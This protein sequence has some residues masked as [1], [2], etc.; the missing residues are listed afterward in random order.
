MGEVYRARDTK[1][2]RD[3]ALKLLPA[4]FTD[5]PDRLARFK[6][7]A[8]VLASLNHPNIAA[9]YGLEESTDVQALVLELVEGPTLADRIAQGPIPIDEALPIA[10]QI[11]DALEGAH[12]QGI[13]HR[14]LKPANIKVR[15]D[16]TVKVL[17]F[18]LA[19]A[20]E[21]ST[22]MSPSASMSPTIT[23]PAL[24]QIGI[25]LGTAAYMSP[26]QARGKPAGKRADIWAFGCLVYEMLAGRRA[27]DAEDVSL[28]L[29][30]VLQ[31]D[32]D[33]SALPPDTPPRV[34]QVLRLC[35]R[36]PLR[37]R[38][39]D[40]GAVRLAL[41]GE[42]DSP[43]PVAARPERAIHRWIAWT[44]AAVAVF[45][46]GY[47]VVRSRS[48]KSEPA[49][50]VT[51]FEIQM[52]P[53]HDLYRGGGAELALTPDGR[54]V[55]YTGVSASGR[56]LYRRPLDELASVLIPGTEGAGI[57]HPVV[58]PDGTWLAYVH[59]TRQLRRIPVVGGSPV[60]VASGMSLQMGMGV[61]WLDR[62]NLAF[63]DSGGATRRIVKVSIHGGTPVT[64]A[65]PGNNGS[66]SGYEYPHVLPEGS[67][68]AYTVWS[69]SLD[70][71]KIAVRSLATG[72]EHV[73]FS[74][75]TPRFTTTGHLLFARDNALWAVPFDAQRLQ[76]RGEPV[77]VVDNVQ[78]NSGGLGLFAISATG[79]LAYVPGDRGTARTLTWVDRQ[80]REESLNAAPREY[81]EP[82]I[83]PDGSR[84]VLGVLDP[85]R[86][87]V[88]IWIWDTVR[89]AL[90]QLTSSSLAGRVANAIAPTWT[91][92]GKSIIF[93]STR[94]GKA[95]LYQQRA[96]GSA[97]PA[98][99]ASDIG[100]RVPLSV[101]RRGDVLFEEP[102]AQHGMRIGLLSPAAPKEV[103]SVL[104]SESRLANAEL[105][106]DGSWLAY[107]SNE[108]GPL[109]V[110]VRPFPDVTRQRWQISQDG[111]TQ[112][113]WSPGGRELF[114]MSPD[115]G[116]MS[117]SLELKGGFITAK[118]TQVLAAGRYFNSAG[119]RRQYDVAPD[120]DRF[121]VM[122]SGGGQ[123]VVVEN[124]L[125]ELK[126]RVSAR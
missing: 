67:A 49:R 80:G 37:D 60:T 95:N 5:D 11:A 118:P 84:I 81:V 18:G 27:F 31:R 45:L 10:R 94:G 92:D 108:S 126:Q 104:Q 3:V 89:G 79:T 72:E 97:E 12:E 52:P 38:I 28:T 113:A 70:S 61:A 16:G 34:R 48:G 78:I 98:L 124:W 30:K 105:S 120:G 4:A 86:S 119:R 115:A 44:A 121:L 107:E 101:S 99:L 75:S 103:R 63:T 9:I 43:S 91:A 85:G 55:I 90:T 47:V 69:G 96:D 83:S 14:D 33:F 25:I 13:I 39:P 77:R 21:P 64:L 29:S 102:Y 114:Y 41:D 110:Y 125:E 24:S 109:Q 36:K 76:A 26:E 65:S 100:E 112:P 46:G 20:L 17:D 117:V 6:R 93:R 32:P 87:S 106:P 19:K 23:T 40:I 68:L 7:E 58:S 66:D 88:G 59:D 15:D 123:I 2:N 22:V 73:L 122:K 62:D 1:L 82:R 57:S 51:R 56:A 71:A 35:L 54:T 42:F 111:G 8:Q 74:G 53:S 50:S 116:L